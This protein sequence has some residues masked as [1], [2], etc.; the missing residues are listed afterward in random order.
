[1]PTLVQKRGD[2]VS[3]LVDRASAEE[4]IAVVK[5]AKGELEAAAL[6]L[7]RAQRCLADGELELLARIRKRDLAATVGRRVVTKRGG[8]SR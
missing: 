7:R 8:R 4:T 6:A 1:M 5:L 2:V 3:V